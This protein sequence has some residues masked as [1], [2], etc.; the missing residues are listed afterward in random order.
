MEEKVRLSDIASELGLSTA[1]V[2]YVLHGKTGMVSERTAVRV[3][4]ALAFRR[5]PGPCH[6]FRVPMAHPDGLPHTVA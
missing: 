4:R 2:S 6:R 5:T 3:R 1:A